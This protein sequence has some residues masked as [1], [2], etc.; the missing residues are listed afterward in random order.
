MKI[1]QPNNVLLSLP[2]NQIL[3]E[4]STVNT[5]TLSLI[6]ESLLDIQ[7]FQEIVELLNTKTL[8]QIELLNKLKQC[9]LES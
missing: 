2:A 9:N 6:S 3:S 5:Q 4:I 1:R 8:S 7:I